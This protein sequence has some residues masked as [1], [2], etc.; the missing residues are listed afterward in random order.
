M[1]AIFAPTFICRK[2]EKHQTSVLFLQNN[3]L[4]SYF[5]VSCEEVDAKKEEQLAP[6]SIATF[7]LITQ[8]VA[9]FRDIKS[10]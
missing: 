5:S 1:D 10:I 7:I 3:S 9:V 4:Y 2:N 6:L 8:N